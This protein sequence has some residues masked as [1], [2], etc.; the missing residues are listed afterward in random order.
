MSLN[1]MKKV[2]LFHHALSDYLEPW[3]DWF[4]DDFIGKSISTPRVN[5]SED[6][7]GYKLSMIAPGLDKKDF[8]VEIDGKLL[9]ISATKDTEKEKS[10]E[11][12][13]RR[14]YN[15]SSFTRT[16]TLTDEIVPGKIVANYE[17]G[18]LKLVIPKTEKAVKDTH[19]VLPV[20]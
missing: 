5:I 9:T 14:E 8:R 17:G 7:D 6:K 19:I 15:Y 10:T 20:N 12:Y 1:V 4:M 3:N 16:F 11:N 13:T 18:V 2:T